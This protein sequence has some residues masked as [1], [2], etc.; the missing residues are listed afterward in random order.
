MTERNVR[1]QAIDDAD[2]PDLDDDVNGDDDD[3]PDDDLEVELDENDD[4]DPE[5]LNNL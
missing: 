3:P 2:D 4:D 1:A 5:T